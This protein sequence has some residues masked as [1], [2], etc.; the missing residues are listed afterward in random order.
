M[1]RRRRKMSPEYSLLTPEEHDELQ[2]TALVRHRLEEQFHDLEQQHEAAS[3]GM[4]IFLATE[5]MFFGALFTG[6]AA[7]RYQYP[8]AFET[9][10]VKLNWLIGS[11]NTVML[12]VSSLTMV[13]A[14]H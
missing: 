9:A 6:L 3:L 8:A 13:L 4:W 14:V 5:V 1:P 2:I 12:L 7:Y 10:S 11:V